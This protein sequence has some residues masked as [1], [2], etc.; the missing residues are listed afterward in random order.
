MMGNAK[1]GTL[2]ITNPQSKENFVTLRILDSSVR[3]KLEFQDG[4]YKLIKDVNVEVSVSEIQGKM[5]VD[6]DALDYIKVNEEA[7]IS[8]YAEYL[9]NKYKEENLDI[10]DIYRLSEMYYPN[11]NIDNPL[12]VTELEVNTKLI[13]K[14]TGVTKNSI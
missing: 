14:G 11:E 12:S 8:G 7:Y 3:D 5:I 6:A 13:I 9:F 2:E 10:F 1:S 4:K